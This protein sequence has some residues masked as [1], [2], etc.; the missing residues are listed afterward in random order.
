MSNTQSVLLIVALGFLATEPWRWLGVAFS[1]HFNED[2]EIIK[3]V[4]TIATA[5]IAALVV[6]LIF[7]PSGALAQSELASRLV[8]L[9][10]ASLLFMMMKGRLLPAFVTGLGLFLLCEF[11]MK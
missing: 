11:L 7:L 6:R 3:Y 4:R 2:D 10:G 5:F 1:S 9:G 8:A